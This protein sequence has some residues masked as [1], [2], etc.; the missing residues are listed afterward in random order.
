MS[1]R[2][3]YINK[4]FQRLPL[5]KRACF[6]LHLSG[7]STRQIEKQIRQIAHLGIDGITKYPKEQHIAKDVGQ[8][9]MQKLI[10]EELIELWFDVTKC[11]FLVNDRT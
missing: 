7:F 3:K 1:K 9:C 8:I 4:P 5:K 6:I 2:P 10:G 11:P